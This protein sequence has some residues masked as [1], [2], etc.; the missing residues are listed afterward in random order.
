MLAGLAPHSG[1]PLVN[2]ELSE[3][4][5]IDALAIRD[6]DATVLWLA[7]RTEGRC[8]VLLPRRGGARVTLLDAE[9]FETLTLTP[10]FLDQGRRDL[11]SGPLSLDAYAVARIEYAG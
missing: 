6:Q 9:A 10:D 1:K 8:D 5:R 4:D 2:V 3:K 11:A 7:N